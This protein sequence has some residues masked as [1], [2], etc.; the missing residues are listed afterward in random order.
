MPEYYRWN[1]WFFLRYV[2]KGIA[3][4]KKSKVNWCPDCGTV[5][6]NEQVIDGCCWRHEDVLVE[7]RELE[8]W[9]FRITNIPTSSSTSESHGRLARKGAHHAAQLDRQIA[10][11]RVK[12]TLAAAPAN[13]SKSSLRVIDTIYGARRCSFRRSTL[14]C[15]NCRNDHPNLPAWSR[16][17][18]TEQAQPKRI[19]DADLATA[20][21]EGFFTGH[22]AINP[23]NRGR[24]P[25][26]VANYILVDYGTGAIMSVPAHDE[27]DFEFAKSMASDVRVVIC[28]AASRSRRRPASPTAGLPFV[29]DDSLAHQLRPLQRSRL[30]RSAEEDGRTRRTERLW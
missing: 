24:I 20:D 12:F 19:S 16:C 25:I 22:F 11:A 5:L 6:A 4:R 23:F 15:R 7:N 13:R 1:Q 27:R 17:I 26:W 30:R 28:R 9:F 3:F 8:Q 21:K 18:A 2:E 10:G 14:W 29:A